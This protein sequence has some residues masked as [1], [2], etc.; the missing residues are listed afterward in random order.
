[1][2]IRAKDGDH[3]NFDTGKIT[4]KDGSS[5]TISGKGKSRRVTKDKKK[6]S[7]KVNNTIVYIVSD[8][9]EDQG[10]TFGGQKILS[11]QEYEEVRKKSSSSVNVQSRQPNTQ[12]KATIQEQI[13]KEA[14]EREKQRIQKREE[15]IQRIEQSN[16]K[17]D[18]NKKVQASISSE[19]RERQS[20][21]NINLK[22]TSTSEQIAA[23][24]NKKASAIS[25]RKI[26]FSLSAPKEL[27]EV[28]LN[29]LRLVAGP[30][31][32][33]YR[34]VSSGGGN[35]VK[36]VK[37]LGSS[38]KNEGLLKT[39]K[40]IVVGTLD[41]VSRDPFAFVGESVAMAGA[42][43]AAKQVILGSTTK[44]KPIKTTSESVSV[45]TKEA[46]LGVENVKI[47]GAYEVQTGIIKKKT[48]T[49]NVEGQGI[50][51]KEVR[52]L[53]DKVP[54]IQKPVENPLSPEFSET[55][56]GKGKIDVQVQG[57]GNKNV[58]VDSLQQGSKQVS[59][60]D[61]TTTIS[62]TENVGKLN[63]EDIFK[64]TTR[65]IKTGDMEVSLSKEVKPVKSGTKVSDDI[66]A[67]A[68]KSE[69]DVFIKNKDLKPTPEKV[70]GVK[71]SSSSNKLQLPGSS[72][73][74]EIKIIEPKK[75]SSSSSSSS[76]G[77]SSSSRRFGVQEQVF[78]M[79]S[80]SQNTQIV[81]QKKSSLSTE[82]KNK[83]ESIIKQ[84][85]TKVQIPSQ[86][87][88]DV[89]VKKNAK[90][91]KLFP[92]FA[93]LKGV[94]SLENQKEDLSCQD[95][96][97]RRTLIQSQDKAPAQGQDSAQR[98]TP[99]QSQDQ[100]PK[101]DNPI[102]NKSKNANDNILK[103]T[104]PTNPKRVVPSFPAKASFQFKLPG[105]G[106]QPKSQAGYDIFIRE[107]GKRIKTNKQ[108][109]PYN[110]ALKQGTNIVDNTIAASFELQKRGTT[111]T[112]DIP[113][114]VL[115]DK[116]RSRRTRNALKVVEKSKNR[117]DTIGEKQG[118]N[119]TKFMRR[120]RL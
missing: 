73:K 90:L 48:Q 100:T 57:Y 67:S 32:L 22:A 68:S 93:A 23:E 76:S 26:V 39:G 101:F 1:M 6:S 112:P 41:T 56:I 38:I 52:A 106:F 24:Q 17:E 49:V 51:N 29:P 16:I 19:I 117:I 120:F 40:N 104:T 69:T 12:E 58:K 84:R 62:K 5:S 20:Q 115:G 72:S 94:N 25:G 118:L 91:S 79:K 55:T 107:N 78:E 50:I 37:E 92:G 60:V 21:N 54:E 4:H 64:T 111:N 33:V 83:A 108:P 42:G 85:N 65:D 88:K 116:F 80:K 70:I 10:R 46:T 75:K 53:G 35:I 31:S 105:T 103:K 109:I 74:S 96:A 43:K 81:N 77:S 28:N 44:V 113:S 47:K 7:S 87:V 13:K 3:I 18:L 36:G 34:T 66:F 86:V 110:M 9:K 99:I 119:V 8:A 98:R 114:F 71:A 61:K 14:E 102:P 27:N 2:A 95:S 59:T 63:N 15:K 30:V 89:I 11:P 45:A 82:M 97:Q